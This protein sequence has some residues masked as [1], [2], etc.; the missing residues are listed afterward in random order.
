MPLALQH[1]YGTAQ[2]ATQQH[3][4]ISGEASTCNTP[5]NGALAVG[6]SAKYA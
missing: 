1:K 5:F 2:H 3:S 6:K 4:T